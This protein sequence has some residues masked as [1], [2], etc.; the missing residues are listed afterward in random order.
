MNSFV[1]EVSL[2]GRGTCMDMMCI[3]CREFRSIHMIT[4]IISRYS[5]C[6]LSQVHC[7]RIVSDTVRRLCGWI[8]AIFTSSVFLPDQPESRRKDVSR[9]QWLLS[10]KLVQSQP[11]MECNASLRSSTYL[12]SSSQ[13]D[14][15]WS[16]V[17]DNGTYRSD[18]NVRSKGWLL[19]DFSAGV[20]K[21]RQTYYQA[22]RARDDYVH[23]PLNAQQT[24]P[25]SAGSEVGSRKT[26]QTS[27][28]CCACV[29]SP[30]C[31]VLLH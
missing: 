20:S 9:R 1:H 28:S 19:Q 2:W 30:A 18:I 17:P 24:S 12:V 6:L 11:Q 31:T 27:L 26:N 21:P 4:F 14:V 7:T 5:W 3:I 15:I 8:S 22:S 29:C 23:H 10:S 16:L 25:T 13:W